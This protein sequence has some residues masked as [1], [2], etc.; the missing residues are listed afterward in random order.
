MMI[1]VHEM[2]TIA[3]L[4]SPFSPMAGWLLLK[5]IVFGIVGSAGLLFCA[6]AVAAYVSGMARDRRPDPDSS[7]HFD[8]DFE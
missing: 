3:Y 4:A 1:E 7:P 2:T 5:Y 6:I 8:A